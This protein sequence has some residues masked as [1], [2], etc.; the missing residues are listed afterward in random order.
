MVP[1]VQDPPGSKRSP[2]HTPVQPPLQVTSWDGPLGRSRPD[3]HGMAPAP[4]LPERPTTGWAQQEG[5]LPQTWRSSLVARSR[6][7]NSWGG[8]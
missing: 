5:F 7:R 4:G 2:N 8:T 3:Q 6:P 1:L